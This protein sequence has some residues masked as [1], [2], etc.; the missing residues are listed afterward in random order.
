MIN[1]LRILKTKLR[2]NLTN[3]KGWK[4]KRKI[5]VIESDDWGSIRM[6][7]KEVFDIFVKKGFTIQNTLYNRFDSLA[8]EEDLNFLFETLAFF[9]D[10]HG[11]PLKITA[12]AVVANPD[13]DR[14]KANDFHKYS[15]EPFI[16]TMK[17]YPKHS[18]SFGLWKKGI[19]EGMFYPQFHGREHLNIHL[20]M[21][22]L[23]LKN[24]NLRFTFNHGTTYS[25]RSDYNYMEAFDN[26]KSIVESHKQ[27]L[28][29]GL[30][31]FYKI[32]G[33]RS[34]SFIAPCYVWH[35]DLNK[36]LKENGI[37]YIQG[38]RAQLEPTE[39]HMKYK[40][41]SRYIG[42]KNIENQIQLIRNVTFEPSSIDGMDWVN[43]AYAQIETAFVWGKPAIITS[44]R[45]NYI[46]YLDENNRDRSL[47]LLK[48]L[49]IK[50]QKKWPE[51]E[52]LSSDQLGDIIKE[53]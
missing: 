1:K 48:E 38:S 4:T 49:I 20:W 26:E 47:K 17:K 6:P 28:K 51:V 37:D 33:Y 15:Y 45:V 7:S 3:S 16:E 31:L 23:Q 8:S 11:N 36:T 24:E 25:G 41:I 52:F 35:P 22:D 40:Q 13:F 53:S 34:K 32:F 44:H 21:K 30:D 42:E 2:S 46:G 19:D 5:L 9:K 27:I 10:I 43:Y 39:E 12:N 14:I 50:V 29:E 18:N